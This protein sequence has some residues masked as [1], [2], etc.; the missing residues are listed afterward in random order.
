MRMMTC[1]HACRASDDRLARVEQ[2]GTRWIWIRCAVE[3]QRVD[4]SRA[5]F[6]IRGAPIALS[7]FGSSAL[8]ELACF[9]LCSFAAHAYEPPHQETP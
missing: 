9:L 8:Y 1:G 6:A 3:A 4:R 7:D 5:F 2:V